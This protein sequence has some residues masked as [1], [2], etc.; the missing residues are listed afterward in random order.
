MLQLI[1]AVIVFVNAPDGETL[2]VREGNVKTILRLA[3][4]DAPERTQPYSQLSRRSLV[5]LCQ[6]A[7]IDVQPVNVDG[8][9][10]LWRT[11]TATGCILIGAKCRM[12]SRGASPSI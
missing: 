11:F 1:A 5:A 6:D 3:E 8:M 10:A 9:A 12:G 4:I 2:A 7:A